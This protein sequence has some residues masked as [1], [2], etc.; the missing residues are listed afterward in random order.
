MVR[1]LVLIAFALL[2]DG[3]CAAAFDANPAQVRALVETAANL[4]RARDFAG[5]ALLYHFPADYTEDQLEADLAGVAASLELFA[6]EFGSFDRI[7]PLAAPVLYVDV[8]VTGGNHAY[9]EAHP[10]SYRVVMLTDFSRYGPGFLVF[11]LVDIIGVLELKAIAYGLPDSPAS[12][13]KVRRAGE[14]MTPLLRRLSQP[15]IPQAMNRTTLK[16]AGHYES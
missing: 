13:E 11:H 6:G 15:A 12:V 10:D 7:E 8:F 4:L 1:S 16:Q 9:W 5:A 3:S 2:L 14:K